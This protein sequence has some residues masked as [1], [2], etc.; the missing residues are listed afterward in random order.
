LIHPEG[1]SETPDRFPQVYWIVRKIVQD[2]SKHSLLPGAV[3][4]SLI[5][6]A[7]SRKRYPLDTH[8]LR[9]FNQIGTL[10]LLQRFQEAEILPA[11]TASL[12]I[13]IESRFLK[14]HSTVEK[15][16][17]E[18]CEVTRCHRESV[19]KLARALYSARLVSEY[20]EVLTPAEI[21]YEKT[22]EGTQ[23]LLSLLGE[24][25]K[26]IVGGAWAEFFPSP[27]MSLVVDASAQ[28]WVSVLY[29]KNPDDMA[30]GFISYYTRQFKERLGKLDPDHQRSGLA[31]RDA[32]S[33][34]VTEAKEKIDELR[35]A[36]EPNRK[37]GLD[38]PFAE[39]SRICGKLGLPAIIIFYYENLV[40]EICDAFA[41]MDNELSAREN[42]FTRYLFQE[43]DRL[44]QEHLEL[45]SEQSKDLSD[46]SVDEILNEL[47]QLTGIQS[48]KDKVKQ[49]ANYARLQQMRTQQGMQAIPTSYH[50]VY[51]GNPGTGKT[52]VARLMGRI[53]KALGVLKKGHVV[54]CDRSAVVAEYVGQTATKTNKLIDEAL[55]GI[56]FIDEAYT[57][58]K[59]NRDF[60][61]EAIDTLL[62]R[63]ED[64]R[65]RLIVIVAGYPVEME[66][67]VESNPGLRSRF[68]RFIEFPDF[69]AH[70]L[71]VI[72]GSMCRRHDLAMT[73]DLK[74]KLI[75]HFAHQI[76][77]AERGQGNGRMVR[78][79]FESVIH[80]QA[81][82][83]SLGEAY[84]PEALTILEAQD[85]RTDAE[86]DWL[87]YRESGK[88][89]LVRCPAC[90][91]EYK[92]KSEAN[93]QRAECTNCGQIYDAEFGYLSTD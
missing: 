73:G 13:G 58:A 43:M 85:L 37:K 76:E 57:L 67:F 54:E 6:D 62:K 65:N 15:K 5:G 93:L 35:K 44:C 36:T 80:S 17:E 21:S 9:D 30:R 1:E 52:T 42:R 86:A 61:Q 4:A 66:E 39:I 88:Y 90:A 87:R 83:L 72:F 74:E 51:T 63:M 49:I 26:N 64:D 29:N 70:E 71:C 11:E 40:L 55:D 45:H 81:E 38:R 46:E 78:N 92:W 33:D 14:S 28:F 34:Y 19:E 50:T 60:G 27:E 3:L 79:C 53:F 23:D 56:L 25:L 82:R 32:V 24:S 16:I 84:D 8:T 31:I 91:M 75:H 7:A 10:D 77:K 48:A 47:D 69:N 12:I 22:E 2:H 68:N 41:H 59:G 89:Y 18:I 20:L